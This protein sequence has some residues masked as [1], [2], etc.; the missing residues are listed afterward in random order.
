MSFWI[1]TGYQSQIMDSK[2]FQAGKTQSKQMPYS[3]CGLLRVKSRE[4]NYAQPKFVKIKRERL[5]RQTYLFFVNFIG[6]YEE[7]EVTPLSKKWKP[8]E[9]IST[10]GSGDGVDDNEYVKSK[11]QATTHRFQAMKYINYSLSVSYGRYHAK[12]VI[13]S[14]VLHCWSAT[15]PILKTFKS[16][17]ETIPLLF[18]N[19]NKTILFHHF[20][21]YTLFTKY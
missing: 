7:E 12:S 10:L 11:I 1:W 2:I 13:F 9:S 3:H 5:F 14:N 16:F 17:M 8:K 4:V 21:Q 18:I 19:Q 15:L 20:H 6:L